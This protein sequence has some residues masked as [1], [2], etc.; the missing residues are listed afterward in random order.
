V[1]GASSRIRHVD[2]CLRLLELLLKTL[3]QWAHLYGCSPVWIRM[4]RTR[5]LLFA[6]TWEHVSQRY[7]RPVL[8][9]L[10]RLE[11][12]GVLGGDAG[13]G[14]AELLLAVLFDAL[15]VRCA[16]TAPD[17]GGDDAGEVAGEPS[18]KPAVLASDGAWAYCRLLD[19][20]DDTLRASSSGS[21]W[22]SSPLSSCARVDSAR[23]VSASIMIFAL[24]MACRCES[25]WRNSSSEV[26]SLGRSASTS[27]LEGTSTPEPQVDGRHTVPAW[28]LLP[29]C[30]AVIASEGCGE[31]S[32]AAG[33]APALRCLEHRRE[34]E[35]QVEVG[36]ITG[37]A[38]LA[39]NCGEARVM[40]FGEA[41]LRC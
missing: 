23:P 24:A 37:L 34:Q 9:L 2:S 39:S 1:C 20:Q 15:F 4:W 18:A 41:V 33:A 17:G 6:N 13:A 19:A 7:T 27:G 26:S 40:V 36:A 22:A 28:S 3:G 35:K 5:L 21:M 8:F 16:C 12:S 10:R 29:N 32:W 31:G 38:S 30:N 25:R 14:L 11:F